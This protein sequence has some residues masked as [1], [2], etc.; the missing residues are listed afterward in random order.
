[1]LQS[2]GIYTDQRIVKVNQDSNVL[3]HVECTDCNFEGCS[4]L[5]SSFER[6]KFTNCTFTACIMSAIKLTNTQLVDVQFKNCKLLSIDWTKAS[7]FGGTAAISVGFGGCI[8]DYSSFYGLK[9]EGL[10]MTE[11]VSHEVDFSESNLSKGNFQKT[12]FA[13]S[14]FQH[15]NLSQADFAGAFN[16]TIDPRSNTLKKAKFTL[17]EAISL[18]QSFDITLE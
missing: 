18:L 4:F 6:C 13:G 17:P 3:Q 5:E 15:T 8:L 16:Y 9:L 10:Q 2:N 1:V 11:C 14:I 12:D 7:G